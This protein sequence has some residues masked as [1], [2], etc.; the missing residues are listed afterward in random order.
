MQRYT[1]AGTRA[2]GETLVN[3]T[4]V[5][6]QEAPSQSSDGSRENVFA[7]LFAMPGMK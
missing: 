3:T 1:A 4:I 2:G 6:D 7:Q 5:D